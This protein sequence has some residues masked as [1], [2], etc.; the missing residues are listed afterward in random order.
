MTESNDPEDRLDGDDTRIEAIR[1]K[2]FPTE[3]D[4]IAVRELDRDLAGR[5]TMLERRMIDGQTVA[6][7][8][9]TPAAPQGSG[10][11]SYTNS[12]LGRRGAFGTE[13]T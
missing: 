2:P 12:R 7:R 9:P 13:R 11:C 3:V 10:S 5:R 4:S 1:G 6:A 8:T